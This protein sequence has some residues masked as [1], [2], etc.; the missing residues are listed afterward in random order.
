M[1]AGDLEWY[2]KTWIY[3]GNRQARRATEREIEANWAW[4]LFLN[5]VAL[6]GGTLLDVGCGQGDF[7]YAARRHGFDVQ[8]V[9]F[10]PELARIGRELYGL[11]ISCRDIREELAEGRM[12]DVVT[13]FEVLEHVEE[14]VGFLRTLGRVGR[15]VV[16]S[17]PS[18]E[19]RPRLYARG[20]DDPPHHLTLWTR[21]SL[22]LA[23]A[24]AGLRPV[25]VRGDR[26][27]PLHLGTYLACLV[28]GNYPLSQ[29]ARGAA[30]RLGA[31]LGWL[32]QPSGEGA[33]SLFAL[34]RPTQGSEGA[35][36]SA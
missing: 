15:H 30:R 1:Q 19:R 29:Y 18:A 13:A 20:F 8:G 22:L 21:T 5:E 6:Y 7:L 10:Q 4:G 2:R 12:Y 33:F 17:V 34:A 24:Q 3:A 9:D 31:A 14:P 16:V 23:L 27:Q 35:N 11:A 28:G 32:L 26:Y 25:L 36:G